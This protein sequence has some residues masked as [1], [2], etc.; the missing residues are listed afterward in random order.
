ME[1]KK[2]KLNRQGIEVKN[3]FLYSTIIIGAFAPFFHIFFLREN[4]IEINNYGFTYL[5]TLLYALGFPITLTCVG[6]LCR[7]VSFN[8]I[9][10]FKRPFLVASHLFTATGVFFITWTIYASKEDMNM[11]YYYLILLT[12]TVV[13]TAF[14]SYL[15]NSINQTTKELKAVVK[16]LLQFTIHVKKTYIQ[17][18]DKK[19]YELTLFDHLERPL[20][21]CNQ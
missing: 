15:N 1:S 14:L 6:T 16:S 21:E 11:T 19:N 8:I 12:I 9:A 17:P 13:T 3:L 18:K 20:N 4:D 10:Q 2:T 5:S 7:F